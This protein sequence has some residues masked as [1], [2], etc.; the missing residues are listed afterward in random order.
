MSDP[1]DWEVR[2]ESEEGLGASMEGEIHAHGFR[3]SYSFFDSYEDGE[4]RCTVTRTNEATG[5]VVAQ[6]VLS[7]RDALQSA[8]AMI[9]YDM[10]A[11]DPDRPCLEAR[12]ASYAEEEAVERGRPGWFPIDLF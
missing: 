6:D 9:D 2:T 8:R 5:V 10:E 4:Q 12:L 11:S 3:W 7:G 1:R